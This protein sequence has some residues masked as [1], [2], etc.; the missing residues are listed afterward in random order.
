VVRRWLTF[1]GVGLLGLAVQLGV[2]C[3]LVNGLHWHYVAATAVAVEAAVLHNFIWH[4]RVTWRRREAGGVQA[5]A[6]RLWRFH[7]LNGAVSLAGNVLIVSVLTG[8]LGVHPVLANLAAVLACSVA[9]FFGSEVL[10]FRTATVL[11][12]LLLSPAALGPVQAEGIVAA[13]LLPHT[14]A[15]WQK[16]EQAVDQRHRGSTASTEPFFAHDAYKRDRNWRQ[17][18]MKGAVEM[19]QAG[20]ASPGA[21]SIDVPDG[22]IHH[23]V[24]AIFVPGATLA[25]VLTSLRQ[26]AGKEADSYE[27]VIASRLLERNGDH[28]RVYMKI[29]RD[30]TITTVTYNTEHQVEYRTLGDARASNRST[31][32]KIAQLDDAGTPKER[33]KKPGNDSGYLWRLNAYWRYEQVPGGVLIECESVSLSRSVPMLVRPLVD[34]VANRIARGSLE[35]TLTTL[36]GV[37]SAPQKATARR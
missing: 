21:A 25:G 34:R 36:R 35:N 26:N 3:L 4:Q 10:V 22:K 5:V 23:W 18:A 28:L 19:F 9:N 7:L 32:T 27:E 33:E 13:E 8:G 1:N 2:L 29:E 24:G 11:V 16:Y 17:R 20:R 6:G 30:A 37:L 12:A 31:A 15:A 14:V